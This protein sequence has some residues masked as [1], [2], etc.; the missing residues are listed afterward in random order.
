MQAVS[1][2][3]QNFQGKAIFIKKKYDSP[4]NKEIEKAVKQ[5]NTMNIIKNNDFN[6]FI[7]THRESLMVTAAKT[8]RDAEK[9]GFDY[10]SPKAT[11]M[12]TSSF[13]ESIIGTAK[14]V[15]LTHLN[16]LVKIQDEKLNSKQTIVQKIKNLFTKK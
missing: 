3:N 8:K 6:I 7:Q 5:L 16:K 1:I 14:A 10:K 12:N 15:S 9:Y 4:V 13:S 11:S 2:Q